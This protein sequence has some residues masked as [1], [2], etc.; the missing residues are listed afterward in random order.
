MQSEDCLQLN[1][2]APVDHAHKRLPV[3][4]WI[5]GGGFVGGAAGAYYDGTHFAEHG[6]VLVTFNYRLGR[7][8]WF[9]HPALEAGSEADRRLR[10]DGP[11][12]GAE[13]GQ[14]NIA[15]FGGDARNVTIF[16]ELAGAMSVNYLLIS[17]Q[18]R[19]LYQKAISESGF[20]R[21]AGSALSRPPSN[22]AWSSPR[23]NGAT[24]DDAAQV[25]ALAGPGPPPR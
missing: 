10:P 25:A 19:G 18:A 1:V 6:V 11:D 3:M 8:G 14:A 13:V 22:R 23:P 9:A 21:S 7:F 20:G 12:R 4:V 2:C 5:Y 17:P 15:A 16:G 24:G